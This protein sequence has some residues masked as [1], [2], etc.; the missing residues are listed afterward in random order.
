MRRFGCD[1]QATTFTRRDFLTR[2]GWA[3][4]G[5]A[6]VASAGGLLVF[7]FPRVLDEPPHLFRVGPAKIYKP[8]SA[9]G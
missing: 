1:P 7:A 6:G 5:A 8:G 3:A 2:A 4:L 9:N